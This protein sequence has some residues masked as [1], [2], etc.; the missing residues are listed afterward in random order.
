MYIFRHMR[1]NHAKGT[2][3]RR[4]N[5]KHADESGRKVYAGLEIIPSQGAAR[6]EVALPV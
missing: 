2:D 4:C 6:L 3:Q 1:G 5:F